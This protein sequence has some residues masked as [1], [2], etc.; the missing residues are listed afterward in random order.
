MKKLLI[1]GAGG[2]IGRHM[3]NHFQER[4]LGSYHS[5]ENYGIQLDILKDRIFECL[6]RPDN[7]S[8]A[9]VLAGQTKPAEIVKDPTKAHALNV[10][11][12]WQLIED[13]IE[14]NIVPIFTSNDSLFGHNLGPF[15]ETDPTN[16]QVI[17]GKFKLEIEHRLLNISQTSLIIRIPRVYG[18]SLGD[19]SLIT[20]LYE[21]IKIGGNMAVASDQL[22]SPLYLGDMAKA[23][24]QAI[25]SNL[26]GLYHL[27]GDEIVTHA[28]IAYKICAELSKYHSVDIKI[29][30][31]SINDFVTYET[32]PLDLSM[33]SGKLKNT[34]GLSFISITEAI[35]KI[36]LSDKKVTN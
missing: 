5:R 21:K 27:G 36:I 30:E 11:A 8:H 13:L 33:D 28:D 20:R 1:V 9:L 31:K 34:L 17:Y 25:K 18:L 22:F 19:G 26:S 23:I 32:R 2:Y 12:T 3:I 10:E 16:P 24:D 7:I 15:S 29:Q 4:A 6:P 14:F 35:N